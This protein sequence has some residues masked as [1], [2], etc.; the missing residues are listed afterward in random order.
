MKGYAWRQV[1]AW[2]HAAGQAVRVR[3]SVG[4]PEDVVRTRW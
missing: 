1:R 3:V 4:K 2:G